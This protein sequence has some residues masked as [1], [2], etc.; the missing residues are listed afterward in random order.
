MSAALSEPPCQVSVSCRVACTL[1]SSPKCHT[2]DTLL[3]LIEVSTISSDRAIPLRS[4]EERDV[5]VLSSGAALFLWLIFA[6]FPP[7]PSPQAYAGIYDGISTQGWFIGLMCA[8]A[9][10]TLLLL[11]I[12]FVRRNKGGKYSGKWIYCP[13]PMFTC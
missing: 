7:L 12:C 3:P 1:P 13:L 5:L 6:L 8:I 11:T 10:L 2:P 4:S 9:L